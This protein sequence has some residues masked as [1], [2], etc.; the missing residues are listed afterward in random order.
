MSERLFRYPSQVL[1]GSLCLGLSAA[2]LAR[3]QSMLPLALA[4]LLG[5]TFA[6]FLVPLDPAQSAHRFFFQ[7]LS[8]ISTCVEHM[9]YFIR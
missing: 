8:K 5:G 7:V 9:I 3:A 6:A 2:N 1:A 4:V